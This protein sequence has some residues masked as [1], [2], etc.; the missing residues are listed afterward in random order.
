VMIIMTS[1]ILSLG[2]VFLALAL[3][4]IPFGIIMTG[5]GVISL[6][7]VVVNNAI[8]LLDYTNQLLER[9]HP[10]TEAVVLAGRTRFRPV[11]MTAITTIL[12]LVPMI[13]GFSYDFKM[14]RWITSSESSLWWY[15]MA[16]S[17][18]MGMTIATL[19]TLIVVPVIFHIMSDYYEKIRK[20]FARA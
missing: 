10:L 15:S 16:V 18:A 9:G 6:A 12:G 14:M 8:V 17:V 13:T 5:I 20:I 11:Y 7:G 4:D 3:A 2:G 19:L 1:V